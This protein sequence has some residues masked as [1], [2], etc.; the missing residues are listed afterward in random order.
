MNEQFWEYLK[1]GI[2]VLFGSGIVFEFAPIKFSPIS[3]ML[4]WIGKRLNKDVK[5]DISQLKE[6]VNE[7]KLDLQDHKVQSWRRDIIE[8]SDSLMLGK[9]RTKEQFD[10]IIGTHDKYEK[11]IEERGIENGQISLAYDFIKKAYQECC[12]N[13]SFYTGK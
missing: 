10:F 7:V 1:Y 4:S 3:T 13:N 5:K 8:F 6:Q 12:D 9:K 11:Y 2:W